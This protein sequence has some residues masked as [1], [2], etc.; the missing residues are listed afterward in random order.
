MK[1]KSFRYTYWDNSEW[2]RMI[3]EVIAESEGQAHAF[4]HANCNVSDEPW[5]GGEVR[6]SLKLVWTDNTRQDFPRFNEEPNRL[7][8]RD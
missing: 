8:A 6:S 2:A 1:L 4:V 3:C 5:L 7:Y